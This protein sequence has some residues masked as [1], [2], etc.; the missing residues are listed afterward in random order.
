MCDTATAPPPSDCRRI[1]ASAGAP[2]R[3]QPSDNA[4]SVGVITNGRRVIIDNLGFD[5]WVPITVPMRGYVQG[6]YLGYCR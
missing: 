1:I 4:T 3:Q 6:N 2:V 5:G